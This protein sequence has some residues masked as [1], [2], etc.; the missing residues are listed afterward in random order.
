MRVAK[1]YFNA[2]VEHYKLCPAGESNTELSDA[3][4]INAHLRN[5]IADLI[6]RINELEAENKELRSAIIMDREPNIPV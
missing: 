4:I 3:K 5:E 2:E 1:K 6:S